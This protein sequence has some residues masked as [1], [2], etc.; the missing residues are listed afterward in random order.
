M[1]QFSTENTVCF[2]VH[3]LRQGVRLV[4]CCTLRLVCRSRRSC[5]DFSYPTDRYIKFTPWLL[6]RTQGSIE[7]MN[8]F[9]P[10]WGH[11][12]V[13]GTAPPSPKFLSKFGRCCSLGK[14]SFTLVAFTGSQVFIGLY[15]LDC[16][17]I[18]AHLFRFCNMRIV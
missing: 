2:S 8:R 9:P 10:K 5:R 12:S 1:S 17:Y 18:I 11:S 6:S 4:L 16:V 3:L 14:S 13:H 15:L 7:R